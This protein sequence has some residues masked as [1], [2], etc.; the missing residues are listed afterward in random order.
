[1]VAAVGTRWRSM[2]NRL[3]PRSPDTKLT[4]V[5][6]PP[7]RLR[8]ATK[9]SWTGSAPVVNTIGVVLVAA[10]T[11]RMPVLLAPARITAALRANRS[12]TIAGQRSTSGPG[13]RYSI[14]TLRPSLKPISP[15]PRRKPAM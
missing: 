5:T 10:I 8:L 3:A 14:A 15:R 4:P 1:M 11:A 7:G 9:P 2:S 13:Q 6:L 12:L